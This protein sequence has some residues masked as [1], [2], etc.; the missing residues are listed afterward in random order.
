MKKVITKT[1]VLILLGASFFISCKKDKNDNN[2]NKEAVVPPTESMLMD[3]SNFQ[4]RAK[5]S[6]AADTT[7]L[8]YNWTASAL[9]VGVWN[10]IIYLDLAVPVAAF[11]ESFSHPGVLK[12][13][14]NWNRAFSVANEG[15][16]YNCR[17]EGI[18]N[19]TTTNWKMYISKVGG[20]GTNYT[21]FVWFTGTSANDGSSG[22]WYL[23]RSP[24]LNGRQYLNISWVK[25]TSL[26]Y[27]LVDPL[28]TGAGNYIEF[29]SINE[30][31]LDAQ[32]LI[33]TSNHAYDAAIQ[34]SK[35]NRNGRVKCE[36]WYNNLNWHCWG[37]NYVNAICK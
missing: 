14:N 10:E 36:N 4:L 32:F 2:Q 17:L 8:D 18:V 23:N 15:V 22:T 26:K 12:S 29:K 16:T 30:A 3:F 24:A 35:A 11:R 21:D 7:K 33:N 27:T 34:W 31:G 20:L 19:N 1:I 28:E 25:N 13:N 6:A 37:V 9:A 5:K